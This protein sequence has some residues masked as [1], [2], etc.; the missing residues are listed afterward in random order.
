MNA[1]LV[2]LGCSSSHNEQVDFSLFGHPDWFPD[3]TKMNKAM[4]SYL[5]KE[6]EN[7]LAECDVE[8]NRL[9]WEL[10]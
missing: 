9:Q 7:L 5:R 6:L 2:L 8:A 4:S 3:Q 1:F 10:L